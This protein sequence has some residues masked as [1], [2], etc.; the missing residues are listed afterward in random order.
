MLAIS[1]FLAIIYLKIS[2]SEIYQFLKKTL[3]T[4]LTLETSLEI[5]K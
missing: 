5:S 4:G 1:L 2:D 3:E